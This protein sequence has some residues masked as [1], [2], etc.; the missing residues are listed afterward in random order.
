MKLDNTISGSQYGQLTVLGPAFGIPCGRRRRMVVVTQ[1]ECGIISIA[2]LD[3]LRGGVVSCGCAQRRSAAELGRKRSGSNATGYKHGG[4]GSPLYGVWSGMLG[5]C[6]NPNATGYANYGGRGISVCDQWL[7]FST[8]REWA[9]SS[10]YVAGEVEL[11]RIDNDGNY[12]PSNCRWAT[13]KENTRNTRMTVK[14][15]AFGE[16]KCVSAWSEDHRANASLWTI[17]KRLV[18]GWNPELA[19]TTPTRS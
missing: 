11:D 17:R 16:T 15:T 1:C 12:E 6:R 8:F 9:E 7:N 4:K 10:G 19:I 2:R 5:R 13:A 3:G 18:A 14:I